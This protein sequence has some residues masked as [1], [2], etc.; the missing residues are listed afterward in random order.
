M[1]QTPANL[2]AVAAHV[3]SLPVSDLAGWLER[4]LRG[5]EMLPRLTPDE[6]L[7]FPLARVALELDGPAR[8]A[9]ATAATALVQR[10]HSGAELDEFYVSALLGLVRKLELRDAI[11]P[12]AALARGDRFDG[13]PN[14]QQVAILSTLIDLRA[15][16]GRNPWERV[17]RE[18]RHGAL[19]LTALLR[20]GPDG[21]EVL[22]S[23]R[24]SEDVADAVYE[25][26]SQHVRQ[27]EYGEKKRMVERVHALVEHCEP[28]ISEAVRDWLSE[29]DLPANDQRFASL[30]AALRKFYGR[31]DRS[32]YILEPASARLAA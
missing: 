3:Q 23:L 6:P 31:G 2:K 17:A 5:K 10:L 9:L 25:V 11:A 27:L 4:A 24:G 18:G 32:S 8:K 26:L 30:D 29:Q 12:L 15:P 19:A 21:I 13:L 7:D 20:S 28:A 22:P 16:L 1:T 14:G